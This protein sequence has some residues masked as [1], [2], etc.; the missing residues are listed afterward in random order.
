[1][2]VVDMKVHQIELILMSNDCLEHS[3]VMRQLVDTLGI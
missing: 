2:N 3:D 1:M